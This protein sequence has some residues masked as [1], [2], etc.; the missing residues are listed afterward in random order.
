LGYLGKNQTPKQAYSCA[1]I[2]SSENPKVLKYFFPNRDLTSKI[3]R[4]YSSTNFE[5]LKDEDDGVML[6]SGDD[7]LPLM[8]DNPNPP[9]AL[10]ITPGD[11]AEYFTGE[12]SRNSDDPSPVESKAHDLQGTIWE[13][14]GSDPN[15]PDQPQLNKCQSLV[16]DQLQDPLVRNP[17]PEVMILND[18]RIELPLFVISETERDR[19]LGLFSFL[20][21]D[22]HKK[23][24]ERN[25]DNLLNLTES[26][27]ELNPTACQYWGNIVASFFPDGVIGIL[28]FIF[29]ETSVQDLLIKN[30][31]QKAVSNILSKIINLRQDY[32]NNF[33][34]DLSF[35]FLN[36]RL[37]LLGKMFEELMETSDADK[38]DNLCTIYKELIKEHTK[39]IE[40]NHYL[41]NFLL[42]PANFAR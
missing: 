1:N 4:M 31:N 33:N 41:D 25:F 29:T 37:R 30:S 32:D 5:E 20:D 6:E 15:S 40:G 34:K 11:S 3:D 17:T 42:L 38:I 8:A 27:F 19:L 35:K 13:L 36:H 28:E 22:A 16:P 24:A 23:M 7:D 9:V 18:E 10:E 21:F 12:L 2:L 14:S 26:N 39:I